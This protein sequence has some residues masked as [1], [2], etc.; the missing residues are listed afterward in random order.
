MLVPII[1]FYVE[2]IRPEFRVTTF[3]QF[4]F[5]PKF[6]VYQPMAIVTYLDLT[7]KN[8]IL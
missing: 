8:M 7:N 5:T 4:F 6:E 3:N 1:N 2:K